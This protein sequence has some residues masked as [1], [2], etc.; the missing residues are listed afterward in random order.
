MSEAILPA[1]QYEE[2][3][4]GMTSNPNRM[5][6]RMANGKK[7]DAEAEQL[8]SS[9]AELFDEGQ[10]GEANKAS[11]LSL[12]NDT[13]NR[14]PMDLIQA[15]F[16]STPSSV[17]SKRIFDPEL[18]DGELNVETNGKTAT[19]GARKVNGN[20]SLMKNAS[21]N[22]S[23]SSVA[24]PTEA[25]E[26]TTKSLENLYVNPVQDISPKSISA[27]QPNAPLLS[28][29]TPASNS[30]LS[31][32]QGESSVLGFNDNGNSKPFNKPSTYNTLLGN[33]PSAIL[34]N[35]LN[36]LA[37]AVGMGGMLGMNTGS[38]G[39]TA[40]GQTGGQQ[41]QAN[42]QQPAYYVQ[43]AVYLDQNGNPIFY[44]PSKSILNLI[45]ICLL[46]FFKQLFYL[47]I[48]YSA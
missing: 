35:G 11:L 9:Y 3:Q 4:D 17:Y 1:Y 40:Q 12:I 14:T 24:S 6:P 32:V 7:G 36:P 30:I 26:Q 47:F 13:F 34:N 29:Y 46:Y 45:I 42:Q 19:Q 22:S 16:P 38:P 15:D 39:S 5:N 37:P 8:N 25:V 10:G 2:E 43:Q 21:L 48:V 28:Q 31:S 33:N 20:M 41:Q 23:Q 27:A 44:R 18:K